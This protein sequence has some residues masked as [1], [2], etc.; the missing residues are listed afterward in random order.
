MLRGFSRALNAIRHGDDGRARDQGFTLIEAAV[1]IVI[2]VILFVGLTQTLVTSFRH[3]KENRLAQQSTQIALEGVEF[4]RSV[5]FA[6]LAITP[7]APGS[8]PNVLTGNRLDGSNFGLAADEDLVDVSTEASA[9]IPYTY[10][11][12]LDGVTFTVYNY[13]TEVQTSLRRVV[14]YV[15]WTANGNQRSHFTT[16]LI[17]EVSSR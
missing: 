17:S 1:A 9:L 3:L 13:V 11:E 7:A 14:V 15:A 4:A 10:T 6:E 16:T 5:L 8:D 12:T 2:A